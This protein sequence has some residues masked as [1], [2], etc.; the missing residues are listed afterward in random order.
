MPRLTFVL[1]FRSKHFT[2][3]R[4][5]QRTQE[6][7]GIWDHLALRSDTL[8]IYTRKGI[9]K[10]RV[11]SCNLRVGNCSHPVRVRVSY[12][13]RL[14]S[15]CLSVCLWLHGF[16]SLLVSTCFPLS[17]CQAASLFHSCT[18]RRA[19][20]P[21]GMTFCIQDPH[22][23]HGVPPHSSPS[24]LGRESDWLSLAFESIPHESVRPGEL[25]HMR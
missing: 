25:G 3:I 20:L 4:N 9:F 2:S 5:K 1:Y 17:M 22:L 16:P 8:Q 15:V 10:R 24:S 12:A 14:P 23:R 21:Y 7:L 11:S 6:T 18:V 19:W 13:P